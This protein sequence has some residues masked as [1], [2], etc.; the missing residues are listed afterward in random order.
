MSPN[1]KTSGQPRLPDLGVGRKGIRICLRS[2]V[3][4]CAVIR[5]VGT[6]DNIA[7]HFAARQECLR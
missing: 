7:L 1:T 3:S 2:V 6:P 4:E 5:G